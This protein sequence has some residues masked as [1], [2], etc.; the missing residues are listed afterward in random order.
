MQK[1]SKLIAAKTCPENSSLWL[2][3]WMHLRD[4]AEIIKKACGGMGAGFYRS[5]NRT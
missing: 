3:L 2:P 5:G 1:L 4:T